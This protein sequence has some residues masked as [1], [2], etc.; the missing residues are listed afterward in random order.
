MLNDSKEDGGRG[1]F[2]QGT[3][4]FLV[5]AV[6]CDGF[7]SVKSI[8]IISSSFFHFGLL[9]DHFSLNLDNFLVRLTLFIGNVT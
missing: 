1:P 7:F 6:T 4:G 8:Q 3:R 2:G 9:L 5:T